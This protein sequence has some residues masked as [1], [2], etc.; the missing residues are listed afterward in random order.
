MKKTTRCRKAGKRF[1]PGAGTIHQTTRL[2]HSA[3]EGMKY[4]ATRAGTLPLQQNS[5][6]AVNS[7]ISLGQGTI[8]YIVSYCGSAASHQRALTRKESPSHI[9]QKSKLAPPR[10]S[11]DVPFLLASDSRNRHGKPSVSPRPRTP[12]NR[13]IEKGSLASRHSVDKT[14]VSGAGE[15]R[16]H[17]R[18]PASAW[19]IAI[20]FPIAVESW[21]GNCQTRISTR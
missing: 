18:Q 20:C 12:G 7:S 5:S 8:W 15:E 16:L 10:S 4:F 17:P 9:P 21:V 6:N 14:R 19:R 13:S 3:F 1:S 11:P 2:S